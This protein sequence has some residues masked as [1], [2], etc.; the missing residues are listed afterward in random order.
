MNITRY[1]EIL[2]GMGVTPFDAE[3]CG[4]GSCKAIKRAPGAGQADAGRWRR[5]L[6][7]E[8]VERALTSR[9]LLGSRIRIPCK[10]AKEKRENL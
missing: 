8:A 10:S 4:C 1:H 2:R 6:C 3:K 5:A 9:R 7:V